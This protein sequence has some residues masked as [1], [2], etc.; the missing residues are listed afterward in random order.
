M[1]AG[2][3]LLCVLVW[4]V[5]LA[6]AFAASERRQVIGECVDHAKSFDQVSLCRALPRNPN[7]FR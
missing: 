4:L 1:R 2:V 7:L 3:V 6:Y 5:L